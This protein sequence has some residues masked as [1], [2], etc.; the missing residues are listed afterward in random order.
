MNSN[1][2][3]YVPSKVS[4]KDFK[5]P[6]Q[7]K[8]LKDSLLQLSISVEEGSISSTNDEPISAKLHKT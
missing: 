7:L 8:S 2:S 6:S 5:N 1:Y 3:R 4:V